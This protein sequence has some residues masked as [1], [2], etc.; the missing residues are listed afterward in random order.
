M[1]YS[2]NG[3][4]RYRT[5][6]SHGLVADSSP[7]RLVQ[8]SYEHILAALAVTDGCLQRIQGNLP[9]REVVAKCEAI[10]KAIR[11]IDHLNACLDMERGG[12]VAVNLRNLYLY[13]L[14]QLTIANATNDRRIV[15]DVVRLIRTV[16]TGWD[17]I[18]EVH[19]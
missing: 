8:V 15:A 6:R 18:V 11:L 10:G 9:L 14:E 5:V 16:K 17:R 3:A 2:Q 19:K 12:A 7:T 4:A 13:M 1:M